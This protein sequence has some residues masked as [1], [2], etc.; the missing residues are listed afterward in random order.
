[1]T[2]GAG[3]DS[4]P[5]IVALTSAVAVATLKEMAFGCLSFA[6][7][8]FLAASAACSPNPASPALGGGPDD[9]PHLACA[10]PS[11]APLLALDND[12]DD[13]LGRI[14]ESPRTK[15]SPPVAIDVDTRPVTAVV[16]S[17]DVLAVAPKTSPP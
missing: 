15:A 12:D 6:L 4:P 5:K 7:A 3:P 11:H 17:I 8:A 10:D 14:A 16:A 2:L 1:M 13:P 9:G